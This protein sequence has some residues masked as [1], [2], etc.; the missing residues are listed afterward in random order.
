MA[1]KPNHPKM[2]T[3]RGILKYP[4]LTKPDFGTREHPDPEGKFKTRFI[5]DN[6]DAQKLIQAVQPHFEKA[7]AEAREQYAELP[8]AVRKKN[9]FNTNDFYT[10][11]Y[12]EETEEETGEYEFR[13]AKKY[14]GENRQTQEKWVTNP[15]A[16]FDAA[17]QPIRGQKLKNIKIGGG[18]EAILSFA[19]RPYFVAATGTAGVSFMLDA[20]Q[21]VELVEWGQRDASSYGFSAQEGFSADDVSEEAEAEEAGAAAASGVD[22]HDDF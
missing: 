17:G 4:S 2:Y 19:I 9:P 7:V 6:E 11:I 5:L 12:D 10:P 18:S 14:S 1:K 22:D 8:V 13:F 21:I 15:P 3:P 16:L 20:A